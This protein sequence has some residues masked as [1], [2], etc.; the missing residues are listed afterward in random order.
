MMMFESENP[1]SDEL[2]GNSHSARHPTGSWENGGHPMFLGTS[3]AV[4]ELLVP[5]E[6]RRFA[7]T[8]MRVFISGGCKNG[9]SR[10][11]QD[12]AKKMQRENRPLYYLA[13][14][15]PTD[16]EDR[17]RIARH[18]CEREG[19]GFETIEISGNI[20]E[21]VAMCD[22]EGSFLL[23]SVTALLANEMFR[24]DAAMDSDAPQKLSRELAS[25][26]RRLKNI[27]FVSDFIFS[28]ARIYDESTESYRK[29]LAAIDRKLVEICDTVLEASGGIIIEYKKDCI[30][31]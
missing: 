11:A 15:L 22:V 5:R 2:H 21:A 8:T 10:Y 18:R 19:W 25:L 9:K 6:L 1:P 29:G 28:D 30:R 23:D 14:M 16:A 12:I 4:R 17:D 7:A 24:P 3:A 13:T 26:A 20:T 31:R 27:V